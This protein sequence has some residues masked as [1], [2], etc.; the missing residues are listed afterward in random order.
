LP[1]GGASIWMG[2][3]TSWPGQG[4]GPEQTV[5]E[6]LASEVYRFSLRAVFGVQLLDPEDCGRSLQFQLEPSGSHGDFHPYNVASGMV[7]S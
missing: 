4:P 7:W 1:V 2:S 6:L 5:T 3:Q